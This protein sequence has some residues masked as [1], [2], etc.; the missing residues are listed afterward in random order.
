MRRLCIAFLLLLSLP[1]GAQVTKAHG[2]YLFRLKLTKGE[3]LKYVIPC[4]I[5]GM[6]PTPYR[7]QLGL[8]LFVEGVSSGVATVDGKVT[9]GALSAPGIS[10]QK[11]QIQVNDRGQILQQ[12]GSMTGFCINFPTDPVKVGHSFVAPIP[13]LA[14]NSLGASAGSSQATFKFLGIHGSGKNR[15]ARLKFTVAGNSAPG[16]SLLIGMN[17][18]VIRK[19]FTEYYLTPPSAEPNSKPLKVTMTILRK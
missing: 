12:A 13:V 8:S 1:A 18:G 16:G 14:L 5:E 15:V 7:V 11:G 17:D 3:R 2:G 9:T 6:G 4:V 19:Y 10:N